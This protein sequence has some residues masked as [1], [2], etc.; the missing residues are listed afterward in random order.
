MIFLTLKGHMNTCE[1]KTLPPVAQKKS[2]KA[3]ARKY[4]L[5][6]TGCLHPGHVI[7]SSQKEIKTSH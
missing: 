2:E 4:Y 3:I 5:R 6:I 1:S 7:N